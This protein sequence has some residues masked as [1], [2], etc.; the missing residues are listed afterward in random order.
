MDVSPKKRRRQMP[1]IDEYIKH[2]LKPL[3]L[4]FRFVISNRLTMTAGMSTIAMEV[5]RPR[6]HIIKATR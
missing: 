6:Q 5:M 4:G 1:K 3:A 2:S